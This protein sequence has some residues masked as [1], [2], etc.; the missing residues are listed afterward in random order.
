MLSPDP[1]YYVFRRGSEFYIGDADHLTPRF[2]C[3]KLL[4]LFIPVDGKLRL[5]I[6]NVAA[7]FVYSVYVTEDVVNGPWRKVGEGLEK[8]DF[9]VGAPVDAKSFFIKAVMRCDEGD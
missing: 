6:A 5:R 3:D 7:G 8:A 4:D 2:V 1:Q 9:E